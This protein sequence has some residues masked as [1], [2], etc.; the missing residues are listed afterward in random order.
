MQCLRLQT[1][2]PNASLL[3]LGISTM[4]L[5]LYQHSS[6]E[7]RTL[8]LLYAEGCL[9]SVPNKACPGISNSYKQVVLPA[10]QLPGE[11]GSLWHLFKASLDP[12][13]FAKLHVSLCDAHH[14]GITGTSPPSV[15]SLHFR[16]RQN[17]RSCYLQWFSDDSSLVGCIS[18]GKEAECTNTADSSISMG[19]IHLQ[20]TLTGPKSWWWTSADRKD[21]SCEHA[22][23]W[24]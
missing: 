24:N 6:R 3:Y 10:D 17:F 16:F 20:L 18:E 5:Q 15:H 7:F 21:W 19:G 11:A 8:D 9:V 2:H 4:S 23:M 13:Q 1:Q 12:L 22:N 14:G